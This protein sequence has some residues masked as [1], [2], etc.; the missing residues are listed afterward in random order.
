MGGIRFAPAASCSRRFHRF[1]RG[2]TSTL[3]SRGGETGGADNYGSR[4][5]S[6]STGRAKEHAIYRHDGADRDKGRTEGE[7]VRIKYEFDRGQ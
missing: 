2:Q 3:A 5:D 4:P 7:N 1:F 6:D